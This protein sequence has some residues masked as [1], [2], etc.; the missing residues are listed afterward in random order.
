LDGKRDF[1]GKLFFYQ[2]LIAEKQ[3]TATGFM[4]LELT[5]GGW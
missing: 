3:K 1:I 4:N 5:A 2:A